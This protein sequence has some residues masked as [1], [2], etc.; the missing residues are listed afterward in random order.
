MGGAGAFFLGSKHAREW[1]AIAPI[2]PAAFLMNQNRAAILGAIKEGGVPVIVLQGDADTAVPA[3]N[4]RQWVDTMKELNMNHKYIEVPG[5]GHGDIIDKGM[6]D[7]FA[8]FQE[9]TKPAAR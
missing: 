9:H 5:A 6:P 2:A 8:F 1:A 4:T 3:A 7:I